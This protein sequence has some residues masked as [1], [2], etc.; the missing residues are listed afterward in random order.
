MVFE[1]IN[2]H[3]DALEKKGGLLRRRVSGCMEEAFGCLK[4]NSNA[5][6]SIRILKEAAARRV[7]GCFKVHSDMH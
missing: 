3:S 4:S 7:S 5:Q 2:K 1:C 6:E